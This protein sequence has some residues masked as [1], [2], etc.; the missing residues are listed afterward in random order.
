MLIF[1]FVLCVWLICVFSRA[2]PPFCVVKVSGSQFHLSISWWAQA[3]WCEAIC[4]TISASLSPSRWWLSLLKGHTST[5]PH[6]ICCRS[7]FPLCIQFSLV[8]TQL[9]HPSACVCPA[10]LLPATADGSRAMCPPCH[11]CHPDLAWRVPAG[12]GAVISCALQLPLVWRVIWPGG[13]GQ[14]SDLC[15]CMSHL[16]CVQSVAQCGV[17]WTPHLSLPAGAWS[18]TPECCVWP[19][20]L[21]LAQGV[22]DMLC[23]TVQLPFHYPYSPLF[24]QYPLRLGALPVVS[25]PMQSVD[26]GFTDVLCM[27]RALDPSVCMFLYTW[28]IQKC[29]HCYQCLSA[30]VGDGWRQTDA[31][32]E[33]TFLH[34]SLLPLGSGWATP[35]GAR[36]GHSP[37]F[38]LC[39]HQLENAKSIKHGLTQSAGGVWTGAG[40]YWAQV[41]RL[42]HFFSWEQGGILVDQI[43]S[44]DVCHVICWHMVKADFS[45]SLPHLIKAGN[46]SLLCICCCI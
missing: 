29:W 10:L 36:P 13:F 26:L 45:F 42:L 8:I 3:G 35:L 5:Q 2:L 43:P 24:F 37:N 41:H 6:L 33:N 11:W 28:S 12:F 17:G 21:W 22:S 18:V 19:F 34:I 44:H 14:K 27:C 39:M 9:L 25:S 40:V 23:P 20:R 38:A 1:I 4:L 15:I 32:F 7:F 31:V 16:L 46:I 30:C